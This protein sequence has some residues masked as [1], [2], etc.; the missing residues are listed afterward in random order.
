MSELKV[1][2][3]VPSDE[4]AMIDIAMRAWAENGIMD[5][6]REKVVGMF[7]PALYLWQG[8]VGII[9]EPGKPI[10]AFIVLRI[11]QMWYSDA[12][13]LE[14]KVV[15]VDPEFRKK[16]NRASQ[17]VGHARCLTEF[18]KRSADKLGIPLLIGVLSNQRTKAKVK[19]YERQF[20]EPAGAFFLYGVKTGHTQNSLEH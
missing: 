7:R 1:R 9:G 10:E 15:F 14:E 17:K 8:L 16:N 11:G 5:I 18:A 20:G 13:I 3:G 4:E 19:L 12:D 6:N 2:L